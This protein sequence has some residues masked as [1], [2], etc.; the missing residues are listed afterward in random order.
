M[1]CGAGDTGRLRRQGYSCYHLRQCSL[2]VRVYARHLSTRLR[3]E[4]VA[5]AT[6]PRIERF[7]RPQGPPA[8]P[9]SGMGSGFV[10]N[11]GYRRVLYQGWPDQ[12]KGTGCL[13]TRPTGGPGPHCIIWGPWAETNHGYL[14]PGGCNGQARP[15]TS[16]GVSG[17]RDAR[18]ALRKTTKRQARRAARPHTPATS[19]VLAA[20]QESWSPVRLKS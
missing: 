2:L 12:N 15:P 13:A 9:G 8:G 1:G 3:H 7:C 11:A 17:V 10:R 14:L 18:G 4:G 5:R 6:F 19:R 16:S 20:V